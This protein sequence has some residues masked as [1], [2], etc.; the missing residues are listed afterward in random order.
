MDNLRTWNP[1]FF[2]FF[3]FFFSSSLLLS[4]S[5]SIFLSFFFFLFFFFLSLF[6]Y[7]SSCFSFP[8]SPCFSFLLE[9][10]RYFLFRILLVRYV[11]VALTV[12]SI[13]DSC[14]PKFRTPFLNTSKQCETPNRHKILR[15]NKSGLMT[16]RLS[17]EGVCD[18][19]WIPSRDS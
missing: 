15:A 16:R 14:D 8:F 19:P 3:S 12:V 11:A 13:L 5:L 9:L 1:A 7:S 2:F 6:L 10:F 18:Q 4:L 17:K